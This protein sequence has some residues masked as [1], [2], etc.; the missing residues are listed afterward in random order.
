MVR[1][2]IEVCSETSVV[3][4]AA[5]RIDETVEA[6][7]A[8]E[9]AVLRTATAEVADEVADDRAVEVLAVL[10]WPSSEPMAA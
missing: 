10:Y 3:V 8:V 7:A 1:L 6:E 4:S 9:V 2:T 5:F